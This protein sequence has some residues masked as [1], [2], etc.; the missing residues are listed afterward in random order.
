MH[1][2]LLTVKSPHGMAGAGE[3]YGR[4][5]HSLDFLG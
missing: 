1:F 2:S 5:H 4:R 3:F